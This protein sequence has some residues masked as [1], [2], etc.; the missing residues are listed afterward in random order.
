[1]AI[2]ITYYISFS[3][4][5]SKYVTFIF[6]F[7]NC[8]AVRGALNFKKKLFGLFFFINFGMSGS[9]HVIMS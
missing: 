5:S 1:M 7:S 9:V 3:S 4:S 8:S 2:G 6:Y